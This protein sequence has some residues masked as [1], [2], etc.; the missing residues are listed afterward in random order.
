MKMGLSLR[1]G[2]FEFQVSLILINLIGF[3]AFAATTLAQPP[4]SENPGVNTQL[5]NAVM[6]AQKQLPPMNLSEKRIFEEEVVPQYPLFIRDYGRDDK[7]T[8]Q[9]VNVVV[10]LAGIKNIIKFAA[11]AGSKILLYLDVDTRC[12]KC[13]DEAPEIRKIMQTRVERRGFIPIWVTAEELAGSKIADLVGSRGASGYLESDILPAPK[14]DVDTAHADEERFIAK[15]QFDVRGVAHYDDQAE[16][17]DTDSFETETEK[18]LTH[19]F[20]ELGAKADLVGVS[21][22]AKDDILIEVSKIAGFPQYS[23]LRAQIQARLKGIA[24]VDERKISRGKAVFA[25]KTK[26][27]VVEITANLKAA[28]FDEIGGGE[29]VVMNTP[30]VTAAVPTSVT[31]ATSAPG[32]SPITPVPS[33]SQPVIQMEIR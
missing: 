13:T 27:S 12:S 8:G 11:P 20:T 9:G 5:K 3:S 24:F 25:L 17:F 26:K 23:K 2:K 1:L 15:A 30:T 18:L 14:D 4:V 28:K 22:A 29:A 7:R 19:A 31:S 10:D 6:D 21:A 33:L 16:L 32:S